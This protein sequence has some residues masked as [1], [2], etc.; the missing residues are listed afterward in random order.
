MKKLSGDLYVKSKDDFKKIYT[1]YYEKLFL[2]SFKFTKDQQTSMDLVQNMFLKLWQ[3]RAEIIISTSL[4][5]YLYQ[6]IR[7]LTLDYLRKKERDN[8]K[9]AD[10]IFELKEE[11]ISYFSK[12]ESIIETEKLAVIYQEIEKLPQKHSEILKMSRIKGLK[13]GEIAEKMDL[14]IRT[15]ETII[16]RSLKQVKSSI[17]DKNLFFI[18]L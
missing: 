4:K 14:P 12:N 2:Y 5:S 3:N 9:L 13:N 17:K 7:N 15:V 1:L 16:Y 10:I 18:F 11:E 8:S 6:S